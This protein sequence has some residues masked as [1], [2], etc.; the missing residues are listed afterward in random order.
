MADNE[1]RLTPESVARI[2]QKAD[3]M[4]SQEPVTGPQNLHA[5]IHGPAPWVT[6]IAPP[7]E[8]PPESIDDPIISE[9]IES[10][11]REIEEKDEW[12]TELLA[13]RDG[14]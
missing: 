2:R 8:N 9:I 11:R 12:S 3:E 6:L 7:R 14:R 10:F 5:W 4:L 13:S 1:N